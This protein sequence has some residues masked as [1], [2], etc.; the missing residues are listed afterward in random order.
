MQEVLWQVSGTP[1]QELQEQMGN[2]WK[3]SVVGS[4]LGYSESSTSSNGSECRFCQRLLKSP[5]TITG[6][7]SA[8]SLCRFRKAAT[9][10]DR[11]CACRCTTGLTS[12]S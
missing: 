9:C 6:R 1:W 4:T 3:P 10:A 12:D 2:A 5:A 7:G 8:A 11:I